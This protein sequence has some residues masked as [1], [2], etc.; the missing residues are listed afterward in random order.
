MFITSTTLIIPTR[1]RPEFLNSLLKRFL[2]TSIK[3]FEIIVVD[4]SNGKIKYVVASI[5]KKFSARYFHTFPSTSHQRNFGMIKKNKDTRYV[6][7]LDDD[8]IFYKNSIREMNKLIS[9][10][11]NQDQVA[12]FGFNQIQVENI[13]FLEKLKSEKNYNKIG[14]YWERNHQNE[15]DIVAIN[16]LEKILLFVEVKRNPD[17]I[18]TNIL[19][20]KS[21]YLVTQFKDYKVLYKGFSMLDM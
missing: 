5:C 12:A 7:F 18:N 17:K 20:D 3:F 21:Q 4:S 9:K 16:E 2:D 13:N 6:M 19:I 14:T 15:I 11:I 1:N 8:V 10:N